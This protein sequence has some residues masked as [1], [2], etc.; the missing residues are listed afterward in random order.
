M[1]NRTAAIKIPPKNGRN[2]GKL[3]FFATKAVELCI[4][5]LKNS[6]QSPKAI[7]AIMLYNKVDSEISGTKL[8][9]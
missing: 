6:A 5:C 3:I 1:T 7:P 2:G 4:D 8:T 9:I